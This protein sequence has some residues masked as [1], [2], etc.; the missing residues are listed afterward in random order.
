MFYIKMLQEID[1]F[2]IEK[3]RLNGYLSTSATSEQSVIHKSQGTSNSCSSTRIPDTI[4]RS[5]DLSLISITVKVE[6]KP[7]SRREESYANPRVR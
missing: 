5:E 3:R 4:D 6:D 7:R 2:C 1:A